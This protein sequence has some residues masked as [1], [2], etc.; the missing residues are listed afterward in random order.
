MG[1]G[2]LTFT[3]ELSQQNGEWKKGNE[4][5][6]EFIHTWL[7]VEQQKKLLPQSFQM[8]IT[9][10]IPQRNNNGDVKDKSRNIALPF[11]FML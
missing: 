2:H 4:N 5:T 8:K 7:T 10:Q 3:S 6:F 9:Q 1:D 11:L